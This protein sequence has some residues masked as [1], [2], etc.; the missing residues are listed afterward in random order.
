MLTA[1]PV[2]IKSKWIFGLI[3]VTLSSYLN[4]AAEEKLKSIA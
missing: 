2:S 3:K 1:L 4:G